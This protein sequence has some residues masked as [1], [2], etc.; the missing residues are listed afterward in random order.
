MASS[1]ISDSYIFEQGKGDS[2]EMRHPTAF[3]TFGRFQPP[4][5][6]HKILIQGIEN[7]I[8]KLSG[9][10]DGYV[11]V[12]KTQN[13]PYEKMIKKRDVVTLRKDPSKIVDLVKKAPLE[14]PLSSYQKTYFLKKMYPET[15]VRFINTYE[16]PILRPDRENTTSTPCGGIFDILNRLIETGYENIVML[17]G[18][19]RVAGFQKLVDRVNIGRIESGQAPIMVRSVGLER[20]E[21]A[22]GSEGMSGSKMRIAAIQNNIDAFESGIQTYDSRGEPN[23]T[24]DE[25]L[26]MI[27]SIQKGMGMGMGMGILQDTTSEDTIP[28]R[29]P[30]IKRTQRQMRGGKKQGKYMKKRKTR[31]HKTKK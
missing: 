29:N 19:D 6:G 10:A 18:S 1:G 11:F 3:F 25:I 16:C 5:I 27:Q 14:N 15:V 23:L 13:D 30:K 17:V 20:D 4:T 24:K 2:L 12:S 28:T 7:E 22:S 21:S 31:K 26:Y 9:N 8:Q